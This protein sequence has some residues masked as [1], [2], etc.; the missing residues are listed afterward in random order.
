LYVSLTRAMYCLF[1]TYCNRRTGQQRHTGWTSGRAQRSLTRFV[2]D[3][4]MAPQDGA[5]YVAALQERAA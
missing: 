4:P 2:R 5:Q 3:G 1:V